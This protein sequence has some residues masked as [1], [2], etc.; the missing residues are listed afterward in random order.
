MP[1]LEG[2]TR[3]NRGNNSR[4]RSAMLLAQVKIIKQRHISISEKEGVTME[5]RPLCISRGDGEEKEQPSAANGGH[6]QPGLMRTGVIP[7][8]ALET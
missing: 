6:S 4:K 8:W 5:M 2:E 1:G 3:N 7:S